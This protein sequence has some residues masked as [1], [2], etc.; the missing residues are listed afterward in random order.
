MPH[1]CSVCALDASVR[2]HG[3]QMIVRGREYRE[4]VLLSPSG[5][6]KS[7][8]HRHMTSC[9]RARRFYGIGKHATEQERL[10]VEWSDGTL[11]LKGSPFTGQFRDGDVL[12]KIVYE[13]A[14]I[15]E[16]GNPAALCTP[17][18]IAEATREFLALFPDAKIAESEAPAVEEEIKV[19]ADD[20]ETVPREVGDR[21]NKG[22]PTTINSEPPTPEPTP[23]PTPP[24]EHQWQSPVAN[25][26]RC[27][28]CGE[29]EQTGFQPVGVSRA[30]YQ[31]RGGPVFRYGR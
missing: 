18:L 31:R 13:E 15:Q 30:E 28:K 26:R 27:I 20:F 16:L 12:M 3:E 1:R 14:K 8:W 21:E 4:V 25:I 24:C 29:Q 11:T 2:D 6:S 10:I 7:S 17:A 19:V 22:S 9:F 23:T 5:P